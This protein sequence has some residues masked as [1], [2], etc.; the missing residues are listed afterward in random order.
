MGGRKSS[1]ER[2][3]HDRT[4]L[5]QEQEKHGLDSLTLHRKQLE[6]EEK[7]TPNLVAGKKS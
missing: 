6:K 4:V 1:S 3:A 7:K 2:E 5:P